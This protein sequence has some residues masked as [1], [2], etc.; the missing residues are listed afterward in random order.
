MRT[1]TGLSGFARCKSDSDTDP[2]GAPAAAVRFRSIPIQIQTGFSLIQIQSDPDPDRLF[3]EGAR[4]SYLLRGS[5]L[6]LRLTLVPFPAAQRTLRSPP[7]RCPPPRAEPPRASQISSP[8]RS[9]G[10]RTAPLDSI[11]NSSRRRTK[12]PHAQV[13]FSAANL[14]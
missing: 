4:V 1:G 7:S 9:T 8:R 5:L 14:P 11:N 13:I 6:V 10:L 2:S 12:G 3:P